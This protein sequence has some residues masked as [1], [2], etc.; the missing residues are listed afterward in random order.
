MGN[1]GRH[2]DDMTVN[3]NYWNGHNSLTMFPGLV[4]DVI[5]LEDVFN[6][7]I[8]LGNKFQKRFQF[9]FKLYSSAIRLSTMIKVHYTFSI[10]IYVILVS[11]SPLN[12]DNNS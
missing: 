1:D 4:L 12:V 6:L 3:I 9:T 11:N 10:Q 7:I 8:Q 5:C 2:L